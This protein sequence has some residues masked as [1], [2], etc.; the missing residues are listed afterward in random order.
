MGQATRR[1]LAPPGAPPRPEGRGGRDGRLRIAAL[2][3][4]RAAVR[5]VGS[6][7]LRADAVDHPRS[8]SQASPTSSR[9]SPVDTS[10]GSRYLT[11][12]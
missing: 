3:N 5:L 8:S 2:V 6:A 7:S 4:S 1:E 10:V 9:R 11:L 12:D